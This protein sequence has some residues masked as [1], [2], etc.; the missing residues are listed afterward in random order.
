MRIPFSWLLEYIEMDQ[1]ASAI[2][3]ILTN[4][5]LEVDAVEERAFSFENVV[6]GE[7]VE[8]KK[9]PDADTLSVALVTDGSETFQVVCGAPNCRT[10]LKTAFARVGAVLKDENEKPF[11]IKKGKL[12]G[13][14]SFGMLCSAKE[15]GLSEEYDQIMEFDDNVK[16]G[17]DLAQLYKDSIFEISLTPNLGH[18]SSLIG[19]AREISAALELPVKLPLA[20]VK[21]RTDA[22]IAAFAKVERQSKEGCPRYCARAITGVKVGDSPSWLKNRLELSGIRSVNNVVD[23]TN[24][25]MLELGHPLH[26][27]DADQIDAKTVI[28]R[29]AKKG[30]KFTTLDEKERELEETDLLIADP[31]KALAIAGVMGGL[32]SEVTLQTTNVLLEAAYFSPTSI[33]KT[34]KR[35]GLSTDASRRF[36]RG[37][38]PN[39]LVLAL[40]RAALLIQEVAGG[41]I[42]GGVLD[43]VDH[44]FKPKQVACRLSR[45]NRL[46]GTH[47]SVSEVEN[48]FHR[49]SMKYSWDGQDQFLVEVPTYRND[50]HE[51]VDLIEEVARIY[52]FGN[53]TSAA[54]VIKITNMPDAPIFTFER[55]AREKLIEQGLQEFLTCDLIGPS[56]LDI[57]PIPEFPK[58]MWVKILNP[59]SIEQSILRTSLLP[60][61]LQVVK[62]NWDHQ[63]QNISGFEVGRIHFKDDAQYREQSIASIVL[64]G[65]SRPQ[66]WG[67]KAKEYDFYD[68]KGIVEDFLGEMHLPS[69]VFQKSSFPLLHPGRQA[70][71]YIGDVEVGILGE[72]S[73]SIIRRLDV[74]QRIYFAELNLHDLYQVVAPKARYQ[75]LP[76]YPGS[77]RDW[78]VT[79]EE[80]LPIDQIMEVVR[81]ASTPLLEK[82]SL[83]DIYRSDKLGSDKKNVTFRF[84]YRD[85]KKTV[86]QETVDK[87]HARL[88]EQVLKSIPHKQLNIG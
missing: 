68:L 21:D 26:A 55:L 82:V 37:T 64:S 8:A 20:H 6:V 11:K 72:V 24:Y 62:H 58:K 27:F 7:V 31:K 87:E 32:N 17:T 30:E 10:G 86:S 77:E 84:L 28:V 56:L 5:G 50:I 57:I 29:Q 9:H 60:G 22:P 13:I 81:T 44:L 51:E 1:P 69:P 43:S 12:R 61:L 15:L 80:L 34:S 4:A 23:V 71:I 88:I 73:P 74:P 70:G 39:I 59:T 35:L 65:L 14:E 79:V 49:L 41:E 19:V 85:R 38:D 40:D 47:L 52:G 16:V 63:N 76:Q 54:P 48:V 75:Q 42:L 53:I 67:D 45:V 66:H 2:A 78:T 46:L 18:C 3:T 83:I 25:V 36:E 33:R